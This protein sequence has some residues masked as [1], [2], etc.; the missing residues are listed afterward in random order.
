MT[1][2]SLPTPERW[3]AFQNYLLDRGIEFF[4]DEPDGALTLYLA[5]QDWQLT[6]KPE[7]LLVCQT[8]Y[9]LEEMHSLLSDGTAEDLG[10]DELA[11][12]AKFYLAQTVA[13][14]K[15][16][17]VRQGFRERAEMTPQYVA[18]LYER[19]VDFS[20]FSAVEALI[21]QCRARLDPSS[22]SA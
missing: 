8:G 4:Q 16:W 11:K 21:A 6:I 19:S 3:K 18:L 14:Y 2:A 1:Q 22:R 9:L 20:T 15:E 17:F 7:G 13:P 5:N 12:Q 10:I